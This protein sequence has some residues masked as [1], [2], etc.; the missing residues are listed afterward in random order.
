MQ[1]KNWKLWKLHL[2]VGKFSNGQKRVVSCMSVMALHKLIWAS[3]HDTYAVTS[4]YTFFYGLAIIYICM[5][6]VRSCVIPCDK[7]ICH[8]QMTLFGHGSFAA[9]S[10]L[11]CNWLKY[12]QTKVWVNLTIVNNFPLKDIVSLILVSNFVRTNWS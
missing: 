10:N 7:V 3:C 4:M 6:W 11:H 5:T 9:H 2:K 8:D 12:D 1:E